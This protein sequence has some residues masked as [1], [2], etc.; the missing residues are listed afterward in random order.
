MAP[1]PFGLLLGGKEVSRGGGGKLQRV[2]DLAAEELSAEPGL[3]LR[4]AAGIAEC[5]VSASEAIWRGAGED[6]ILEAL[7]KERDL[8][9]TADELREEVAVDIEALGGDLDAQVHGT[10]EGA[11]DAFEILVHDRFLLGVL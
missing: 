10:A 4:V 7:S 2:D 9:D 5:A 11:T 1:L 8:N 3:A 6:P